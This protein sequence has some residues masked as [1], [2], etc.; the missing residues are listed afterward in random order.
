MEANGSYKL[1][2]VHSAVHDGS[3]GV[4][5]FG[6]R[7]AV[8]QSES[9]VNLESQKE[10]EIDYLLCLHCIRKAL[11]VLESLTVLFYRR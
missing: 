9:R 8:I 5:N 2:M 4:L 10:D 3:A 1:S 7:Y 6:L 11:L